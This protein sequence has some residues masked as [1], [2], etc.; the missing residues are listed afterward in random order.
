MYKSKAANQF[1]KL[2]CTHHKVLYQSAHEIPSC[3]E[4]VKKISHCS[5][6]Y[7]GEREKT[8]IK[9][10]VGY[11]RN[12]RTK[13]V[14]E[15]V[16]QLVSDVPKDLLVNLLDESAFTLADEI[17][18]NFNTRNCMTHFRRDGHV[19][20]VCPTGAYM[21]T[22]TVQEMVA[23]GVEEEVE[24]FKL[25][26]VRNICEV[27]IGALIREVWITDNRVHV[28]CDYQYHEFLIIYSNGSC[29]LS[30]QNVSS[31]DQLVH[32]IGIKPNISHNIYVVD[33]DG[34]LSQFG[35]DIAAGPLRTLA[36]TA[37]SKPWHTCMSG[38]SQQT[39]LLLQDSGLIMYDFRSHETKAKTYF[40]TSCN[41]LNEKTE[42][43]TSVLKW[44]P[45]NSHQYFLATN[46][47]LLMND[48]R[49][50]KTP[51]VQ[52]N[53]YLKTPPR[54]VE[55]IYDVKRDSDSMLL[56]V[57][58]YRSADTVLYQMHMNGEQEVAMRKGPVLNMARPVTITQP[59]FHLSQRD[60]WKAFVSDWE[61]SLS[62]VQN[63]LVQPCVGVD[64]V[65]LDDASHRLN[66]LQQSLCGD[67]FFQQ[68]LSTP[69]SGEEAD[70]ETFRNFSSS[71]NLFQT[72]SLSVNESDGHEV[73]RGNFK[74]RCRS[75]I[76]S[77]VKMG[78]KERS[79]DCYLHD[80]ESS[81]KNVQKIC[82][83]LENNCEWRNAEMSRE[84]LV[85]MHENKE[86]YTAIT[87]TTDNMANSG[88]T[89]ERTNCTKQLNDDHACF[90]SKCGASLRSK[91]ITA[92][93]TSH[94]VN[95]SNLN[96][97]PITLPSD[98]TDSLNGV[99]YSA[100]P[101]NSLLVAQ[102][103]EDE[104]V[105]L[106]KYATNVKFIEYPDFAPSP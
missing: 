1:E 98:V 71:K 93:N 86:N 61:M 54:F 22:L 70:E 35:R 76:D 89:S 14:M 94:V 91:L 21:D 72:R 88:S 12:I 60:D 66:F 8:L 65:P 90:C 34:S 64:L 40:S 82:R 30:L 75:W 13:K 106:D 25:M 23:C 97:S 73:L 69:C 11:Y 43:L 99:Q 27:E 104:Y 102:W 68:L 50:L 48:E 87:S 19:Y 44:N 96:V 26:S 52:C 77:A 5:Q 85:N 20:I 83:Q 81:T 105:P 9:G 28:R 24:G 49:Y 37:V 78:E 55:P 7:K 18:D 63:R 51:V 67:L 36:A 2:K 3:S 38:T 10:R 32:S 31:F 95:R 84:L 4:S 47:A 45:M 53:H 101:L 15:T 92:R 6:A 17:N 57:G 29:K 46:H 103:K 39:C 62:E 100:K 56:C 41:Y 16:S 74:E 42:K 59:S 79:H 33:Q 58:A 80:R